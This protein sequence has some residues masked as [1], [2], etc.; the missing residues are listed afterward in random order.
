LIRASLI[1]AD[2]R[3]PEFDDGLAAL[4]AQNP[5][6]ALEIFKGVVER[7]RERTRQESASFYLKAA[8][9]PELV[10][11]TMIAERISYLESEIKKNPNYVDLQAELSLCYLEQAKLLWQKGV[12]QYRRTHRLCP[13]LHKVR[14]A[15]EE[16]QKT[17][18]E[19]RLTLRKINE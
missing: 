14:L 16:T 3:C 15:L 18:E 2:Y 11:D 19:I 12:E 1:Y 4:S 5:T 17:Y 7:K 8:L 10:S 9:F 6:R 13:S